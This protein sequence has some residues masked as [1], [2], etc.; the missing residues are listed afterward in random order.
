MGFIMAFLCFNAFRRFAAFIALAGLTLG[1]CAEMPPLKLG[2]MPFNSPLALVKT[3]EPLARHLEQA[4]GRKIMVHTATDYFT[5]IN[6][7][8]A[9]DFDI[10]ITGPHFGV[11]ASERRMQIL[12]RYAIDLQPLFVV[13]KDSPI[14][15]IDDLRGKTLA[16]PSRLSISSIGGLKWLQ[17]Q[18]F[19]LNHDLRLSEFSAHGTAIAAVLHGVADA[20][21]TTLALLHQVPADVRAKTRTLPSETRV[22]HFMTLAHEHLGQA[23]IERIRRALASFPNTPAGQAFFRETG[24]QGYVGVSASDLRHLRPF[25]ELTVSVIRQAK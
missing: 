14:L 12:Y 25:I 17:D 22:P 15:K 6:A 18:G 3:H 13:R 16:L 21:V 11:M 19:R 8:L 10:A 5:H 9:G 4:L 1:A 20:A 7:L 23:E 2:I 24:Y